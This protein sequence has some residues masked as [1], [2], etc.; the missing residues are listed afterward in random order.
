[1]EPTTDRI[2]SE[3]RKKAAE[4]EYTQKQQI[5]YKMETNSKDYNNGKTVKQWTFQNILLFWLEKFG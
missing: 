4:Q 2:H 1:M 5:F 3:T